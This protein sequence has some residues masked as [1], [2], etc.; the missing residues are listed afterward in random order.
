M[1]LWLTYGLLGALAGPF[2]VVFS[3]SITTGEPT[4]WK[5]T[6]AVSWRPALAA[7]ALLIVVLVE[8]G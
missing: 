1:W 6:T 8:R 2:V 5:S 3:S 4:T 7:G